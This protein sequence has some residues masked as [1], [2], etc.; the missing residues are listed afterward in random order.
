MTNLE[1]VRRMAGFSQMDLA[2]KLRCHAS[3]VSKLE[4]GWQIR[5]NPR[6]ARVF[7]QNFRPAM[8]H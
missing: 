2:V 1:Y 8:V 5:V 7:D 6:I 4:R 3:V